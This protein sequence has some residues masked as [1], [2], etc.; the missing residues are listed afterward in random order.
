MSTEASCLFLSHRNDLHSAVV[1]KILR[2]WAGVRV[3]FVTAD[4][5]TVPPGMSYFA[6][7]AIREAAPSSLDSID[8]GL[9]WARRI[10]MP[11]RGVEVGGD[12]ESEAFVNAE[13]VAALEGYC[14]TAPPERKIVNP[15]L[16]ERRAESKLWQL[17][18]ARSLGFSVPETLCSNKPEDVRAAVNSMGAAVVKKL[19]GTMHR[20]PL[21]LRATPE[22]LSDVDAL[23]AAPL[24]VQKL[25]EAKC[26]YRVNVFLDQVLVSRIESESL[27][28]R[29]SAGR[30]ATQT[31][32]A[33]AV[34][35]ACRRFRV[36]AGLYY[37]VLDLVED[38]SGSIFFLE[39]NPQ[40]Q[41]LFLEQPTGTPLAI[42]FS[43]MLLRLLGLDRRVHLLPAG[44]PLPDL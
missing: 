4:A 31:K 22:I 10:R 6:T 15:L 23:Q 38:R 39:C 8:Y 12:E 1:G 25:V 5:L 42:E 37:C 30:E 9:V 14:L 35:A 36:A 2:D 34:E 18:L 13:C 33:P 3:D 32:L 40:G 7:P 20:T 17:H 41:F 19:R 21:T 27:D 28:W 43:A 24:I 29:P 26:H 11:Q 16:A 44:V